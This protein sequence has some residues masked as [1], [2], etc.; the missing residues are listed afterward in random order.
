MIHEPIEVS[1]VMPCLNEQEALRICIEK[2]QRTLKAL[3]I[4]GEVVIADNGSTDNSVR[5]AEHLG[6]RVVHQPVRGYGAAYLAGFADARGKYLLMGDSDDTYDFTDL[7][8]FLTPLDNGYDLVIGNR[9]KEGMCSDAM[10]W[11][12]LHIGNPV[13]SGLL[14]LLF[15]TDIGDCHCG[16]RSFT[17]TAYTRMAL[18]TTGMEFASEMVVR[19]VEEKLKILE[20]PIDYAPRVGESKLHP[21]RDAWR[22]IRFLLKHRLKHKS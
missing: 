3:A 17:K 15:R 19:A 2:A 1:V 20:I 14:R 9:F 16:M 10:P 5:I 6:A 13:L 21:V 12:N 18:Q 7:E 8:R 11:A 22:H 4:T